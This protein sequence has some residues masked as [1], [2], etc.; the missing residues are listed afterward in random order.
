MVNGQPDLSLGIKHTAQVTP[1]HC[2]VGLRLNSLQVT[3]LE[4]FNNGK[5]ERSGREETEVGGRKREGE[6]DRKKKGK[7]K[8]CLK[9]KKDLKKEKKIKG[10]E[11][12]E[13]VNV[14]H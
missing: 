1:G 5:V 4:W 8:L 9:K 2:K 14:L 12:T 6:G 7:G 10:V 13:L 11:E 3:G